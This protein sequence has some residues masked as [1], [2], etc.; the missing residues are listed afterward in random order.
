MGMDD[1][2]YV[3]SELGGVFIA[4][5]YRKAPEHVFPTAVHDA[6]DSVKW[7]RIDRADSWTTIAGLSRVTDG[8]PGCIKCFRSRRRPLNRLH[9]QRS[10][11]WRQS[12]ECGVAP[13]D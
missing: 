10:L 3:V 5:G 12:S 8:N 13:S 6:W 2:K 11:S 9:C 7:V 4:V 1:A